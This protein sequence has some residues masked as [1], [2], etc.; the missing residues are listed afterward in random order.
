MDRRE[1]LDPGGSVRVGRSYGGAGRQEGSKERREPGSR[2][3]P[4]KDQCII[5]VA[6]SLCSIEERESIFIS[7]V[8]LQ[9]AMTV[10]SQKLIIAV[11]MMPYMELGNRSIDYLYFRLNSQLYHYA[12]SD[13]LV[14][15]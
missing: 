6:I 2:A 5:V 9:R 7:H 12:L 8:E 10:R 1:R 13:L 11:L 14:I 3:S 4:G 15:I